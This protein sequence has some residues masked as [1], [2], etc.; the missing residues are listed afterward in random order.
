MANR[1]EL[2]AAAED[3][4]AVVIAPDEAIDVKLS[5]AKIELGVREAAKIVQPDDKLKPET[6]AVLAEL[7][8]QDFGAPK[9]EQETSAEPDQNDADEAEREDEE[10]PAAAK[11]KPAEPKK[12]RGRPQPPLGEFEPVRR[13]NVYAK[14]LE[15]ALA[16]PTPLAKA[17]KAAGTDRDKAVSALKRARIVN[18]IDY[19]LDGDGEGVLTIML[20]KGVDAESVWQTAK[21][22]ATAGNG[23]AS[24]VPR[25]SRL[26]VGEFKPV[27]KGSRLATIVDLLS[28]GTD[29]SKIAT[30]CK[31]TEKDSL[32]YLRYC[33]RRDHGIDFTVNDGIYTIELPPGKSAADCVV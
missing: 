13:G 15:A 32:W 5:A 8:G 21:E 26:A 9:A 4:N 28:G 11:A 30:K 17:I 24:R 19:S 27:R 33:L 6:L 23:K 20:P 1:K 29:L 7:T 22:K 16:G 10:Q 31:F 12:T 14:L 3:L 25:A 18:G 2:V